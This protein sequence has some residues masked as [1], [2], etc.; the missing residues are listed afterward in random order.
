MFSDAIVVVPTDIFGATPEFLGQSNCVPGAILLYH[1]SLTVLP[2]LPLSPPP[3]RDSMDLLFSLAD[4][5]SF[6]SSA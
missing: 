1:M 4:F 2:R 6:M 3:R 5:H